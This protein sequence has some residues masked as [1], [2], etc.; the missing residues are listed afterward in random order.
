[1]TTT[2]IERTK[3]AQVTRHAPQ[4]PVARVAVATVPSRDIEDA[5]D[6][7]SVA[8]LVAAV[9]LLIVGVITMATT[10][11]TAPP[12]RGFAMTAALASA[13]FAVAA[14]VYAR[15]RLVRIAANRWR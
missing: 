12:L 5:R 6:A 11:I 9:A 8:A 4:R 7:A 14:I 2:Q 3:N 15:H 1:M 13:P 10:S